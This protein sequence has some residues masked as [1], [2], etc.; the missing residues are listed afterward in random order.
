MTNPNNLTYWMYID[1]AREWRWQLVANNGRII[2]DS[3]EGYTTEANCIAGI[4][5]TASSDGAPIRKR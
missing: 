2:A 5:L 4:N 3:G 1:R